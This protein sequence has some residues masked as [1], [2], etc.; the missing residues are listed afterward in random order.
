M[1]FLKRDEDFQFFISFVIDFF[2]KI[3]FEELL[4]F[5]FTNL[6]LVKPIPILSTKVQ[7]SFSVDY[8]ILKCLSIQVLHK[9]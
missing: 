4:V 9:I 1:N 3:S 5:C 6:V 7:E 2:G 8:L